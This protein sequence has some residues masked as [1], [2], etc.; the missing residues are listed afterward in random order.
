MVCLVILDAIFVLV[1][2][3]LDLSIIK[4]DHGNVVP[5]VRH[6]FVR[7]LQTTSEFIIL[8]L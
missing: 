7:S 8:P 4:L 1:E 5:E 2:L 3:L 6:R